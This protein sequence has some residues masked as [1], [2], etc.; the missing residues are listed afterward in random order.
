M[1]SQPS[2]KLPKGVTDTKHIITGFFFFYPFVYTKCIAG[3]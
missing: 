3:L 1:A 2:E